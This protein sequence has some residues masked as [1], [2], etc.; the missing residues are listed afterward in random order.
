MENLDD[1]DRYYEEFE[2]SVVSLTGDEERKL[3]KGF[4]R[5][6]E[7]LMVKYP[8]NASLYH[9]LGVCLYNLSHWQEEDKGIIETAFH[10]AFTLDPN[11]IFSVMFLVFFYFDI[12]RF[13]L[14]ERCYQILLSKSLDDIPD[15][16]L[17]K[18]EG[19]NLACWLYTQEPDV[20]EVGRA[21]DKLMEGYSK[22]DE[23]DLSVVEPVEVLGALEKCG[24]L[25]DEE[26]VRRVKSLEQLCL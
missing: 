26:I 14:S 15:W 25:N 23:D 10:R 24:Y 7:K 6:I 22:L 13:H 8:A 9:K 2:D 20:A 19:V 17:K 11:S 16:R 21:L 3:R 4:T 12:G 1:F 18:L 5:K